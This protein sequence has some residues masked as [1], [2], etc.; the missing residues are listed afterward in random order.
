MIENATQKTGVK[1][2]EEVKSAKKAE[3]EKVENRKKE[4]EAEFYSTQKELEGVNLEISQLER[5]L[6]LKN[7]GKYLQEKLD[8]LNQ[9]YL[10]LTDNNK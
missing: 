4:L 1:E 10:K 7:Y 3:S 9:E 6:N 8:N 2:S 5:L